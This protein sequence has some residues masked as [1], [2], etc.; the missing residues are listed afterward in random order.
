MEIN[1]DIDVAN[2]TIA[3]LKVALFNTEKEFNNA[4]VH[5]KIKEAVQLS[6]RYM[7]L[8]KLLDKRGAYARKNGINGTEVS[9][10]QR[11][12]AA[13]VRDIMG[14]DASRRHGK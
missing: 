2:V 10:V 14:K 6:K 1:K 4:L 3:D 8:S 11:G 12:I 9:E 7:Q 5:G 13:E